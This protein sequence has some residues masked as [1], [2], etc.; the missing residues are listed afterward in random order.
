MSIGDKEKAILEILSQESGYL[1]SKDIAAKV[2]VSTRTIARYVKQI[3]IESDV[4][5]LII[6]EKGKG[7]TLNYDNYLKE[8]QI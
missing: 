5:P 3:N 7:Y 1:N 8:M 2:G 6:S 4:G